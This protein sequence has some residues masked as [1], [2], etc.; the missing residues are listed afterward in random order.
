MLSLA[1]VKQNLRVTHSAQDQL[2][3]GLILSAQAHLERKTGWY[4]GE[5]AVQTYVFEGAG[6]SKTWLVQPPLAHSESTPI[7]ITEALYGG[8]PAALET[9]AYRIIGRRLDRLAGGVWGRSYEYVVTHHAGYELEEAP[10]DLLQGARMLV[11]HWFKNPEAAVVG[12][13]SSEV[14]LGL[15]DLIG[16]YERLPI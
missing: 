16:P 7:A 8:T 2:I 6:S 11:A 13:I 15:K 4:L 3:N 12:S 5:P 1:V 10:D 14:S 9:S